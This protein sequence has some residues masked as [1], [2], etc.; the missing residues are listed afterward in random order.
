[1]VIKNVD[2]DTVVSVKSDQV[3]YDKVSC[4][5][6]RYRFGGKDNVQRFKCTRF[7]KW[8]QVEDF[9]AQYRCGEYKSK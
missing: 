2:G 7:P 3:D 4:L 6:C 1:M 9:P 8:Y 5:T